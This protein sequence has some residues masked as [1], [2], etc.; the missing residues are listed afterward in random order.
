MNSLNAQSA[1]FNNGF[2]FALDPICGTLVFNLTST[3]GALFDPDLSFS[4][5]HT[6]CL[7]GFPSNFALGVS[8]TMKT[9]MDQ[10]VFLIN[11]HS[12]LPTSHHQVSGGLLAPSTL[13]ATIPIILNLGSTIQFT[14]PDGASASFEKGQ[15]RLEK[16]RSWWLGGA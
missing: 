10:A 11:V 6:Q 15:D 1:T 8:N 12:S 14:D 9:L 4:G 7:F 5:T 13:N 3:L 16:L 2:T